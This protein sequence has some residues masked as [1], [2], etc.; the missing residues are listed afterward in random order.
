M[1]ARI[2]ARTRRPTALSRRIAPDVRFRPR[3][4]GLEDRT[5]PDAEYW[6]GDYSTAASD[7]RNW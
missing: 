2:L 6:V 4:T 1:F 5:V 7:Y 3:L